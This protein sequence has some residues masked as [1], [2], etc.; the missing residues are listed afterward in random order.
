M[1]EPARHVP[2][3]RRN[4][5]HPLSDLIKIRNAIAFLFQFPLKS[6]PRALKSRPES[7]GELNCAAGG[8]VGGRQPIAGPPANQFPL[9][10]SSVVGSAVDFV[11]KGHSCARFAGTAPRGGPRSASTNWGH[12][13]ASLRATPWNF[14]SLSRFY[15]R[16]GDFCAGLAMCNQDKQQKARDA[17]ENNF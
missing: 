4:M 6:W 15:L 17:G 5:T 8:S 2:W 16:L 1:P 7:L 11:A 9:L 14:H 10:C 3:V 12:P 13:R